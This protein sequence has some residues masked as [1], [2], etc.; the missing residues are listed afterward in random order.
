MKEDD[1]K[2]DEDQEIIYDSLL[3]VDTVEGQC[4]YMIS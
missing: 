2:M 3:K 4:V 1:S